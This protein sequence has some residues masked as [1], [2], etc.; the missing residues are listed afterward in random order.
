MINDQAR[1]RTVAVLVRGLVDALT[2]HGAEAAPFG[3]NM[4]WVAK[5]ATGTP[6]EEWSASVLGRMV[7]CQADDRDALAWCW[8]Q[9][10]GADNV[11]Y[12]RI[13][14]GTQINEAADAIWRVIDAP[15][16]CTRDM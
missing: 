5:R 9:A 7:I 4:V 10:D 1:P 16:E 3:A 6:G 8:L 12:E 2:A 15:I 14:P 11:K 13:C